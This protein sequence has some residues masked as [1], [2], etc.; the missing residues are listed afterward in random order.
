M[1]MKL[2]QVFE[3]TPFDRQL[4]DF[5]NDVGNDCYRRWYPNRV[6]EPESEPWMAELNKWLTDNGMDIDSKDKYFHVLI[7][8]SW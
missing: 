4:M 1:K 2:L 6:N 8:F 7:S 3:N 5:F